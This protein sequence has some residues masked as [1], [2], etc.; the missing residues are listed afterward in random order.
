MDG[1][2]AEEGLCL[3]VAPAVSERAH[4]EP[5]PLLRLLQRLEATRSAN[6]CS[7]TLRSF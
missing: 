5:L 7:H 1:A 4:G 6:I 3:L 2:L